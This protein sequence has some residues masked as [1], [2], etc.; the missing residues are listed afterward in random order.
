MRR[1][2]SRAALG[3]R[4][5]YLIHADPDAARDPVDWNPEHSRR[6]RAFTIYAALRALGR[7]GVADLVDRCC[8]N[9]RALAAG[10]SALPGCQILN[11]IV[12]N[13]V[14]LR[15]EDDGETDRVVAAVQAGGEAWMGG[16]VWDGR[17]AIRLSVSSWQTDDDDVARTIAAF[18]AA[19][20]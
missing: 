4:S 5:A 8:T 10:L 15:F 13:Q 20:S 17:R 14:L 16:T 6:A 2:S 19:R 18:T 12:L 1:A 3:I 9:A 11:E 7:G